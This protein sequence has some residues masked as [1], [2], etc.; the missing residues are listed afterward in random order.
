MRKW[1]CGMRKR[2]WENGRGK[3]EC[4]MRK[5]KWEN[6]RGKCECGMRKWDL[7]RPITE[8]GRLSR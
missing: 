4:G 7:D 1:E 5:R 8:G 3:V 6:E 2:K